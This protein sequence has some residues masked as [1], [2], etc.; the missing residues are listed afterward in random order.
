MPITSFLNRPRQRHAI[1]AVSSS[2]SSRVRYG[3]DRFLGP[4]LNSPSPTMEPEERERMSW[5]CKR[6]QDEKDRK[7]FTALVEQL[8]ISS[9]T[10]GINSKFMLSS[11][12]TLNSSLEKMNPAATRSLQPRSRTG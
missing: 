1:F 5:L 11:D 10:G 6:I 9:T 12:G 2:S 3:T 4:L 8:K 7:K